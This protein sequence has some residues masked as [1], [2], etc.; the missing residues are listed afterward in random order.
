MT[1]PYCEVHNML[2]PSKMTAPFVRRRKNA[3][4]L[5]EVVFAIM[6]VGLGVVAMMH[7]F[8]TGA[9]ANTVG[10][11]VSSGTFLVQ[12]IRALTDSLPYDALLSCHGLTWSGADAE[13][14]PIPG[15]SAY[16]QSLSVTGVN[17]DDLTIYIGPDPQLIRLTVTVTKDGKNVEQ[18]TWLRSP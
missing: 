13:G 10:N 6:I 7:L 8:A 4:T 15:L 14:N 18:L 16:T 11:E 5:V 1:K 3:F 2:P 12:Q 17:P 9:D